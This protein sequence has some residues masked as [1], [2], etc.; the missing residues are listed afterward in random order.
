MESIWHTVGALWTS[1][2]NTVIVSRFHT[3]DHKRQKLI[4][5]FSPPPPAKPLLIGNRRKQR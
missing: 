3:W 2:V 4:S 1:A 5:K